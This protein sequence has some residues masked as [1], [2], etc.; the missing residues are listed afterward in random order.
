MNLPEIVYFKITSKCNHN[1][2]YCYD[3]KNSVDLDF[4]GVKK[5]IVHL[6][7]NCVKGVVLS[8]GEPLIREDASKIIEEIKKNGMNV[9]L[10]TNGDFFFRHKGA[11]N[12]FVDV[13]GLP[14]D[15]SSEKL[16]YRSKENFGNVIKIL[17][18]Y[19]S[20]SKKPKLRIGTVI[21]KENISDLSN[22]AE[23]LKNYRINS[24]KI[25]QFIPIGP[26]AEANQKELEIETKSFEEATL[27]IKNNY[28][29]Y[30]KIILSKRKQRAAAYFF[31][32][33]NGSVFMPK[34]DP[35]QTGYIVL[36]SVFDP[37]TTKKWWG[38]AN[39][40][41]YMENA[42][43]TLNYKFKVSPKHLNNHFFA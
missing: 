42:E 5:I 9:Y 16:N 24:W 22:I 31:I 14:L 18:Y 12:K 35:E 41:N 10:D 21:T 13:L 36:G 37:D 2:R 40:K 17:D 19:Q 28:S 26:N 23:I 32:D 11:I 25:Y 6:K 38:V 29:K 33:S 1:C 27:P 3:V 20:I 8:G 34:D 15:Y 30:F 39:K 43:A 7:K 4:E